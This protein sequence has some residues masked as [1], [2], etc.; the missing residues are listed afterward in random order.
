[1]RK[2]L[3]NYYERR[4]DGTRQARLPLA[5]KNNNMYPSARDYI[6]PRRQ[7]IFKEVTHCILTEDVVTIE[8]PR[9]NIIRNGSDDV[10]F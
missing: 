6:L 1:M 2:Y 9:R 3:L 10:S 8:I 7:Y 5:F 4:V